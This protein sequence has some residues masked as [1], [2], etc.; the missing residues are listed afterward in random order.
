M[1]ILIEL[2]EEEMKKVAGGV[3]VAAFTSTQSA[4]GTLAAVVTGSV[5]QTTTATSAA[6][7]TT[8]TSTSV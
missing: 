6:Q 5:T 8:S 3:G 7:S 2:S 1:E 4:S